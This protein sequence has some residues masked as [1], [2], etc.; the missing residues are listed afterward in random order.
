MD[1]QFKSKPFYY[2]LKGE[3]ALFT[4]PVTKGGGEKFTYPIPTYQAIKGITEGIYWKPTLHFFIFV[5]KVINTVQTETMGMRPII[6]TGDGGNDLSYYTY[7]TKVEYLVKFHFEWNLNRPDLMND[8]QE[9]KHQQILLRS[10]DKGGRRDVFIGTRECIGAVERISATDY[11]EAKTCYDDKTINFGIMFHSFS[12]PGESYDEPTAGKLI[13]NFSAIQ[14]R[15]GVITFVRPEE[16]VIRQELRDYS[17][18]KFTF[19][20]ITS[21]D[22]EYEKIEMR[23]V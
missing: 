7:L 13:S 5:M 21:V 22:D 8:R 1:R 11:Q 18:K 10:L 6:T 9:I 23:E 20:G 17:I 15:E 3:Y 12:Y 2:R 14:M 16:C 19:D 4:D